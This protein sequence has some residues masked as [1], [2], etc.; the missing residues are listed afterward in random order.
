MKEEVSRMSQ[1][2]FTE[3]SRVFQE[4]LKDVSRKCQGCFKQV[5]WVFQGSFKGVSR[6]FQGYFKKVSGVFQGSLKFVSRQFQ[7]CFEGVSRTFRRGYV[8]VSWKLQKRLKGLFRKFQECFKEVSRVF[9]ESFR[10]QEASRVFYNFMGVSRVF[11]GSFK[12][13]FKVF[14]KGSC[15]MAL[16]AASRAEGGLVLF[17]RLFQSEI[18]WCQ[19]AEISTESW[20]WYKMHHLNDYQP[21]W[22]KIF[23]LHQKRVIWLCNIKFKIS[24]SR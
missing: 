18:Y 6:S 4:S 17:G 13:T 20:I 16:I 5:S 3:V 1:G 9:H 19:W 14:K 10:E 2:C 22:N 12:K 8:D 23:P 21:E 24:N 15:F 11:Q 7:G